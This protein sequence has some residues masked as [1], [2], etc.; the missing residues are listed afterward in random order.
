MGHVR[1]HTPLSAPDG[2]IPVCTVLIIKRVRLG[3]DLSGAEQHLNLLYQQIQCKQQY[4][5]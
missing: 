1:Q 2:P 3:T 5:I 4:N